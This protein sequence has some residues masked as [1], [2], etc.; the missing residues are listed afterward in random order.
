MKKLII[1]SSILLLAVTLSCQSERNHAGVVE[2]EGGQRP[3]DDTEGVPGYLIHCSEIYTPTDLSPEGE[4]GCVLAESATPKSKVV[5]ENVAESWVWKVPLDSEDEGKVTQRDLPAENDYH[6]AFTI[7]GN[8]FQDAVRLMMAIDVVFEAQFIGQESK[9]SVVAPLDSALGIN[10]AVNDRVL[11]LQASFSSY[12]PSLDQVDASFSASYDRSTIDFTVH[13]MVDVIFNRFASLNWCHSLDELAHQME[14]F[15]P[16]LITPAA[17]NQ[18]LIDSVN[19]A[20]VDLKSQGQCDRSTASFPFEASQLL[21]DASQGLVSSPVITHH[22]V[23]WDAFEKDG[24]PLHTLYSSTSIQNVTEN[25]LFCKA[26]FSTTILEAGEEKPG[27]TITYPDF[28]TSIFLVPQ[29]Q[30]FYS[31]RLMSASFERFQLLDESQSFVPE[32]SSVEINCQICLDADFQVC[33]D[34]TDI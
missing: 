4:I 28:S 33:L 27:P 34:Q 18:A 9:T 10:K 19:E 21:G 7:K 30:G 32:K 1:L 24:Q 20:V 8:D 25:Y 6:V 17:S 5:L 23:V 22:G 16:P 3:S 31:H 11:A 15:T 12:D 2:K 14:L 13:I 26:D 29:S